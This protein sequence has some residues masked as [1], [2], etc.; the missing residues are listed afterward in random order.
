[1]SQPF[2]PP[3][4]LLSDPNFYSCVVS[5]I[6]RRHEFIPFTNRSNPY[7]DLT[8]ARSLI[9]YFGRRDEKSVIPSDIFDSIAGLCAS[10]VYDP[11][12]ACGMTI[13]ESTKV[14]EIVLA[15][16]A[17][18]IAAETVAHARY[19][20]SSVRQISKLGPG[21]RRS[22]KD[23][24]RKMKRQLYS[25]ILPC[26]H[27]DF[28]KYSP[29]IRNWVTCHERWQ[30][31]LR[32]ENPA[33]SQEENSAVLFSKIIN[34]QSTFDRCQSF[35]DDNDWDSSRIKEKDFN[36]LIQTLQKASE[37][38]NTILWGKD[39]INLEKE[40]EQSNA[41]ICN[42][43]GRLR[44]LRVW[45]IWRTDR[46]Y[47]SSSTYTWFRELDETSGPRYR[48]TDICIFI[49]DEGPFGL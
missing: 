1:M 47:N 24:E 40:R 4:S 31:N 26:L 16:G 10:K 18:V 17:N 43:E 49:A 6:A 39:M 27:D 12:I 7:T 19:I 14:V 48:P 32:R 34:L 30:R 33:N 9:K 44:L 22:R 41:S 3:E 11:R 28:E 2:C 21:D 20:W 42:D 13:S 15:G 29:W 8:F 36:W 46:I 23:M 35:L 25:F 38:V 37:Q 5:A 45:V